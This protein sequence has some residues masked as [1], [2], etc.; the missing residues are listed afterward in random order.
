MIQTYS[1][2][3]M[4][5]FK[6]PKYVKKIKN[7]DGVGEVGNLNCGDIMHL[8]IKVEEDKIKDI[9]FQTFGCPAAVASSDVVC[10]LVKGKT[11]EQAE[12][13][14]KDD[15]IQKLGGMPLIKIHCSVLGIDALKRA[16][17]DYKEKGGK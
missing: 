11:L 15:I 13:L 5:H 12:K 16:I 10:E 14:K 4:K 17:G 2:E 6:N 3:L 7:P 8:E 1:K 9:G